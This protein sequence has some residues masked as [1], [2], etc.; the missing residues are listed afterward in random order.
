LSGAGGEI[1]RTYSSHAEAATSPL[2][3][4]EAAM[5][6]ILFIFLLVLCACGE[7]DSMSKNSSRERQE[8]EQKVAHLNQ[9]IREMSDEINSLQAKIDALN[10]MLANCEPAV[11]AP[12]PPRESGSNQQSE[13]AETNQ[14][15]KLLDFFRDRESRKK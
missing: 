6:R 2:Q 5:K 8:L 1:E 13:P 14:Q 10:G 11:A 9:V 4:E 15:Q 3:T 7:Y 12:P